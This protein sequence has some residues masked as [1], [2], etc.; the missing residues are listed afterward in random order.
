MEKIN[1][2]LAMPHDGY[3]RLPA[4]L[5]FL[6]IGKTAFYSGIKSGTFPQPIKLTQR[7]SVWRASD[8]RKIVDGE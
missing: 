1:E 6:A 2:K 8:I 5:A 3:V 4:V 7:T